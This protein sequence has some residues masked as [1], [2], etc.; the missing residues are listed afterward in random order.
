MAEPLRK[1]I[2]L[3]G[4]MDNTVSV[5]EDVEVPKS[6]YDRIKCGVQA[7]DEIFGGNPEQGNPGFMKGESIIFTG[8]PGAGKS[9]MA[10]QLADLFDQHARRNVL[11]NIGEES[12]KMIKIAADRI[13][14]KK[15]F[16]IGRFEDVNDLI[17]HCV[18][19]GVEILIQDSMQ[20]LTD[21]DLSGN[22]KLK[23]IVKKLN[24]FAKQTECL[25]IK[26]GHSTKNGKFAGPQ[27]LIHD[28][29][30]H[31]HLRF[32]TDTGNRVLELEKNR[33]GPALV[34]YEFFLS[35][36]GLDLQMAPHQ[37]QI[38]EGEKGPNRAANRRDSILHLIKAKLLD[39]E[40]ISGYCFER[41]EVDCS[42]NFWR[43]MV[44]R[45][46]EQLKREGHNVSETKIN[47]RTHHFIEGLGD[48]EEGEDV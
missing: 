33:L 35:A 8:V 26:V 23:S 48:T 38:E 4:G 20:S 34:P 42:G 14:L 32:D 10:L 1:H 13:G 37:K 15:K 31:A 25:V 2:T 7:I 6:F 47:N 44:M 40:K 16:K 3:H 17:V 46:C 27:E 24:S 18:N 39:G 43:V 22:K 12:D 5:L 21:G 36:H 19:D 29:D 41:F 30:A 9:T 45:A 11:Y 28:V